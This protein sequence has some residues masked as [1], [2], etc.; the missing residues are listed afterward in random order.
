MFKNYLKIAWRYLIH[1]KLYSLLNV[2]GLTT[3]MA[4]AL[5]I[6]LWVWHQY[7][8]DRF[9]PGSDRIYKTGLK[10]TES[11]GEP[12]AYL[13]SPMPLADALRRD[14]PG[15][16]HVVMTDWIKPH[17][18]VAGDR[19]IYQPGIIAEKDFLNIF[20][21][22][23]LKGNK[24]QVLNDPY[25]I[26]L[27]ESTAATLFGEEEPLNKV[28]RID[29]QHDLKVTGVLKDIPGNS[30]LQ[31]N[32][33]IPY[34]YLVQSSDI[35]KYMDM[36]GQITANVY[37]SLA[38]GVSYAQVEP[39]L[40]KIIARYNPEDYQRS[41]ATVMMQQAKDWH[42]YTEFKNGVATG[43]L[44]S[45]VRTFSIIGLLVLL[46]ACINF[47]NLSTARSEKRAKE[48]GV[49]KA[50]GSRR[51]ELILQFL[52][53]SFVITF[54]AFIL[55]LLLVQII[56]PVFNN[57]T[58]ATIRI[59]YTNAYFWLIMISYL[60]ITGLLAGARPAFY[61]SSFKPLSILKADHGAMRSRKALVLIQFTCSITL[62]ISTIVIY[63]QV[64]YAQERPTGYDQHRLLTTDASSDLQK[65]YTALKNELLQSGMVTAITMSS[66]KVTALRNFSAIESW[67]G[68]TPGELLPAATVFVA[69]TNYF[70][71]MGIP[72]SAGRDFT[73]NASTDSLSVI[74][75]EAA[76][77]KM[78]LKDPVGKT[79]TWDG[80]PNLKIIGIA[81]DA[82]MESP[83]ASPN[84]TLFKYTPGGS[85]FITYRLS[86]QVSTAKAIDRIAQ[87]FG[88]YNAAYPYVYN[89]VDAAYAKKFELEILIGKLT[90]LF[91]LLAIFISC[92]GLF[93]LASYMAEQR[94]KEIGIRK[95]LGASVMQLWTLLSREFVVLV[96]ISCLLASPLAFY[97]LNNWLDK[98]VYRINIG[99]L[100]FVLTGVTTMVITVLTV[101]FQAIKT[102]MVNPVRSLRTE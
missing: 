51:R 77:R 102:A 1:N 22:P 25:S 74:L 32:Y 89:F 30:T 84:P 6:G 39:A 62:I 23:L 45:Y 12:F 94:T 92:L 26:V 58:Q 33:L 97:F 36:W 9:L 28:V 50:I 55:A 43:G 63:Q 54:I 99:P 68:Q 21:Y 71:T 79:I 7:S 72:L 44:I 37:V 98:Y 41:H 47:M 19:K 86:D 24:E 27:T 73:C 101:S 3:G 85:K 46:I 35:K 83:F 31:F 2:L 82:I 29:N 67:P 65:N 100:V 69:G 91:S 93:G 61:L 57:L 48:V 16:Q 53:E 34:E 66:E 11:N 13:V 59:P 40:N 8:Y 87:I 90:G 78:Q 52:S 38:P 56:L 5:I 75:N 42:L 96:L 88:K 64:K 18:L 4:V 17:G 95:V 49:R 14:V 15:I 20:Q 80:T 70:G 76:I 10:G 60:L 81:K